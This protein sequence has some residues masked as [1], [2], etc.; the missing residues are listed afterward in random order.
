MASRGP[1]ITPY[2]FSNNNPL[3]FVDPDG[4]WPDW[5]DNAVSSV[6]S[7]F[8]NAWSSI[9]GVFQKASED[10]ADYWDL[11][12]EVTVTADVKVD[13]GVQAGVKTPAGSAKINL[14]SIE[15]FSGGVD[16]TKR[17][18]YVHNTILDE[19]A[20][21]R[22]ELS[23]SVKTPVKLPGDRSLSIGGAIGQVQRVTDNNGWLENG[24]YSSSDY[25]TYYNASLI[26]PIVKTNPQ[27]TGPFVYGAPAKV[28]AGSNFVGL[29]LSVGATFILGVNA[30]LKVGYYEK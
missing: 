14:S 2:N 11:L 13:V 20:V 3:V 29:D 9:T 27:E 7:A 18:G 17:E 16:L 30:N 5:F 26:V 25:Q 6:S 19:G 24:G 23:V 22:Q 15:L 8:S 10:A 12:P 4:N 28:T 21:L 1:W